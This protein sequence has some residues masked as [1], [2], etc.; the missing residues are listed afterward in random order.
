MLPL[1]SRILAEA[2]SIMIES[3][4]VRRAVCKNICL[5]I[6][7]VWDTMVSLIKFS[8][9]IIDKTVVR[10]PRKR[11]NYWRRT[12]KTYSSFELNIEDSV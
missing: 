5:N 8:V 2:I 12:L 9:I 7:T 3:I 10:N 4:L 1:R 11:H 6:L